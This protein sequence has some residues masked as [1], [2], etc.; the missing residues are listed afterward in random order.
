METIHIEEQERQ[1][2]ERV[3]KS[4]LGHAKF[5][6]KVSRYQADF[7]HEVEIVE[8]SGPVHAAY[9]RVGG[10]WVKQFERDVANGLYERP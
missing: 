10:A 6:M 9:D 8:L 7:G 4:L 5:D 2:F 3:R 1:E